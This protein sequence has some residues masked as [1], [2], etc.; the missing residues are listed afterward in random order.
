MSKKN[1]FKLNLFFCFSI[2]TETETL[3]PWEL[4]V[5]ILVSLMFILVMIVFLGNN[6]IPFLGVVQVKPL[7]RRFNQIS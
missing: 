4:L 2:E 5:I 1:P 7:Y 3:R 6:I